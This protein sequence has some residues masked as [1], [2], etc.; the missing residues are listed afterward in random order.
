MLP[1]REEKLTFLFLRARKADQA[2]A[3]QKVFDLY[4]TCSVVWASSFDCPTDAISECYLNGF[5][6]LMGRYTM[7]DSQE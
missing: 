5:R 3:A 6:E 4:N 2:D 7:P 1:Q